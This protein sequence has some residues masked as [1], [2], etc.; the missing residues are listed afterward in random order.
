[1]ELGC[2]AVLVASS[3]TR[4]ERPALMA[5]AMKD[6]VRAGRAAWEA[7]R[8]TRRLHGQASTSFTGMIGR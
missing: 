8:I 6:A 7:G 4:A 2:D 5:L 1:M 3:V